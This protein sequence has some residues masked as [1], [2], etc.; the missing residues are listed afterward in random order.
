MFN[1]SRIFDESMVSL[2]E[3]RKLF[4]IKCSPSLLQRWI[5]RGTGDGV[6]LATVKVGGRRFTSRE[7]IARF[8]IESNQESYPHTK[9]PSTPARPAITDRPVSN[10]PPAEVESEL[11][12]LGV[13]RGD[14]SHDKTPPKP[15]KN[16]A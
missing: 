9:L 11:K 1:D 15:R 14:S 7:A 4:P 10:I 16:G 5:R 12:R 6:F 2:S 8:L 13:K 3:A